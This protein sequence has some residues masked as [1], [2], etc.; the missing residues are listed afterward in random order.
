MRTRVIP[1]HRVIYEFKRRHF[2]KIFNPAT[3]LEQGHGE[4]QGVILFNWCFIGIERI[5]RLHETERYLIF[6]YGIKEK[7]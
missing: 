7:K 5:K 1:H 6:R 3:R 4:A 2:E